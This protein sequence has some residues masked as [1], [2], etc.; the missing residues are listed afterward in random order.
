MLGPQNKNPIR[1]KSCHNQIL[2]LTLSQVLA[3]N[4]MRSE[5]IRAKMI[6]VSVE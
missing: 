4:L 5:V 1:T 6:F 3:Y 2:T